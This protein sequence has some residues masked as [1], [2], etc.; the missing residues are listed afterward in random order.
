V[1]NVQG[2][3]RSE[4]DVMKWMVR[5]RIHVLGVVE[6]WMQGM[7]EVKVAGYQWWGINR[8]KHRRAKRGSGGAGQRRHV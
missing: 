7:E 1:V 2:W 6:H 8:R 5:E 3:S 4:R